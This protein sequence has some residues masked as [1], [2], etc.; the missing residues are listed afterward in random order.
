MSGGE[1]GPPATPKAFLISRCDMCRARDR[2]PTCPS[3]LIVCRLGSAG[4]GVKRHPELTLEKRTAAEKRDYVR[5][6]RPRGLWAP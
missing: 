1:R 2:S 5:H 4:A 3:C 6:H